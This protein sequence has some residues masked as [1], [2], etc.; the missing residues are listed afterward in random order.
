MLS[1]ALHWL[2]I[3]SQLIALFVLGWRRWWTAVPA[4]MTLL[5]LSCLGAIVG[6]VGFPHAASDALWWR[7]TWVPVES[8]GLLAAIAATIE[9]IFRRSSYGHWFEKLTCRIWLPML[10]ACVVGWQW[11]MGPH[12]TWFGWF[13]YAREQAWVGLALMCGLLVT[14]FATPT[15]DPHP[16]PVTLVRHSQIFAALMVAHAIIAPL[17]RRG[18]DPAGCQGAYMAVVIVC[19]TGWLTL[20]SPASS[21]SAAANRALPVP[22]RPVKSSPA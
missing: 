2:F 7:W 21:Q 15:H 3:A 10:T 5:F 6:A 18:L 20:C 16:E 8:S 1:A 13:V 17:V 9:V 12:D 4:F 22:D 11:R 19:C 14:F